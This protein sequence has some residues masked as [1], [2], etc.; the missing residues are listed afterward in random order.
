MYTSVVYGVAG[1]ATGLVALLSRT[2]LTGYPGRE[3]LVFAGLAVFP[4]LLGH[5]VFNWALGKLPTTLVA[6]SILGEPIGAAVLAWMLL[7]ESVPLFTWI[8][9]TMILVGLGKFLL[10][11]SRP[12]PEEVGV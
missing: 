11:Q 9:G 7:G 1:L 12:E 2:S 5:T 10:S 3:W 6:L 8:G 4:T